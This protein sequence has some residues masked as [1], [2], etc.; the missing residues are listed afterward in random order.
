MRPNQALQPTASLRSASLFGMARFW[1][2]ARRLSF[3]SLDAKA[4]GHYTT[5]RG[6]GAS[7]LRKSTLR[8][9][10]RP[11]AALTES[12]KAARGGHSRNYAACYRAFRRA[13]CVYA[14]HR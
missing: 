10:S 2:F 14:E 11:S 6:L 3:I 13:D 8:V 4:A 12:P 9:E 5:A 7:R 1:F